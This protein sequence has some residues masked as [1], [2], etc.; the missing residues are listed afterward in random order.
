MKSE[1]W[2]EADHCPIGKASQR[3]EAASTLATIT[4]DDQPSPTDPG[5]LR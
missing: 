2:V 5:A 3:P 4:R 1:G